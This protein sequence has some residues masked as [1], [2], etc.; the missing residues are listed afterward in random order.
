MILII[1]SFQKNLDNLYKCIMFR[2]EKHNKFDYGSK[3]RTN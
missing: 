1:N 2:F 3:N